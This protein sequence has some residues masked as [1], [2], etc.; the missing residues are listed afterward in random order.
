VKGRISVSFGALVVALLAFGGLADHALVEQ[1]RATEAAA[2]AETGAR[3][4]QAARSVRATLAQLE[5]DVLR[6]QPWPGVQVG[7]RVDPA[8]MTAPHSSSPPYLQRS[9]AELHSLLSSDGLSGSGLP[10]AVVAAVALDEPESRS[11]V[12]ERLLDGGLAVDPEELP[13][14]AEAVGIGGDARVQSLRTRLHRAPPMASLPSSGDFRRGLTAEDSVEG[15]ARSDAG[16]LGY[17]VPVEPLLERAGVADHAS[18]AASGEAETTA[19][20]DTDGLRLSIAYTVPGR[21]RLLGLR[22]LLW[23]AVL[24]CAIGFVGL[25]RGLQ[26]EAR[27]VEREKAF[28][29]GV[30][31]ELRTPL[32]AIRL[33]AERLA[34]GR[35]DAREYG[36]L[37]A[38][39][40]ERLEAL[41]ERVLALPHGNEAL[42]LATLNPTE[43]VR[44]TA[45]LATPR[46]EERRVTLSVE[47]PDLAEVLWDGEAV[48]QALLN[49]LDNAIRHGREGGHVVVR[50]RED[51]QTLALSVSDDGP[52][53]GKRDRRRI[54]GRF[55]RGAT[56]S[57]GTGLGLYLVDRVARAHGGRVNLETEEG[58]GSTFTLVLPREAPRPR[59]TPDQREGSV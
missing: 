11:R 59:P 55:E 40:S 36:A 18:L 19:V 15:W 3:A 44:S 26:R 37:V 38:R 50:A 46:A 21:L 23:A 10:E 22:T 42:S 41:V 35:G 5:Q 13:Y 20:P 53:I 24:A 16:L 29:T 56:T 6:D 9:E 25:L 31:H 28:L 27:A 1:G 54:F 43:I 48:Q 4:R 7:R 47:T 34:H 12:A 32:A 45:T 33:F 52:G 57:S 39:E 14:L 51:G 2:R 30:T 8:L 49:L 17:E 58:R